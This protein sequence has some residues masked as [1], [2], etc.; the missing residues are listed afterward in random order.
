MVADDTAATL[1]TLIARELNPEIPIIV[2]ANEEENIQRLYRAG[3]DYVQSL[4][5]TGGRMLISTVFEDEEVLSYSKQIRVVRLPADGLSGMTLADA[6]V[7]AKTGS[8]IVAV[9]RD[10]ETLTEF[11]PETF[12]FEAGDEVV[13]AGTDKSTTEF[14]RQFGD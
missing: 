11:D 4:A 8:T 3:A 10:G 7:R 1:T 2:R 14:D 12:E 6:D 9:L 5:T 13:L